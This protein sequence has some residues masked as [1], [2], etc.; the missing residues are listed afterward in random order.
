M[1][2]APC[3]LSLQV[4]GKHLH[5]YFHR[6]IEGSC[7]PGFEGNY[8][9][10]SDR[11]LKGYVVNGSGNYMSFAVPARAYRARNVHPAHQIATHQ[12]IHRVGIVGHD[13]FC[14]DRAAL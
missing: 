5:E 1:I 11:I 6:C 3:V 14:H 2:A 13:H 4:V 10:Q 7:Y 8:I 12:I 9:A